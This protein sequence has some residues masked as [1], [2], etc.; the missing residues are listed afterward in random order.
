MDGA[1]PVYEAIEW[2]HF[3]DINHRSTLT[4]KQV[5]EMSHATIL[6]DRSVP[7][8]PPH[9]DQILQSIVTVQG[10]TPQKCKSITLA[11]TK[12]LQNKALASSSAY[13]RDMAHTRRAMCLSSCLQSGSGTPPRVSTLNRKVLKGAH[14]SRSGRQCLFVSKRGI[15]GQ[16]GVRSN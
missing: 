3:P 2:S 1:N 11:A 14:V 4:I 5:T 10:G 9:I 6:S 15:M 8:S 16:N 13:H 12:T 7:S